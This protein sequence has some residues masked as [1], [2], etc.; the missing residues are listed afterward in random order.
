MFTVGIQLDYKTQ[1]AQDGVLK[2]SMYQK[3]NVV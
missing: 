3:L 2:A 1:Q